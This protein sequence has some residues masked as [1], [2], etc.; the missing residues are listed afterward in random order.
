MKRRMVIGVLAACGLAAFSACSERG[1]PT[2]KIGVI[3]ELTGDIPA[4]GTSCRNAAELA[5]KEINDAG[6]IDLGGTKHRVKLF[7]EDN[8]GKADPR[9]PPRPA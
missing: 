2:V 8:A 9:R 4:V 5:A 7:I 3:A 1:G 6:G